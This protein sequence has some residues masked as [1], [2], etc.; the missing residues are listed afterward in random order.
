MT[1]QTPTVTAYIQAKQWIEIAD[2]GNDDFLK[3]LKDR[4]VNKKPLSAKQI[5]WLIRKYDNA[6]NKQ[7]RTNTTTPAPT[8]LSPADTVELIN[9][10]T[11][12]K[13]TFRF[14][15]DLQGKY[16]VNKALSPAQW[17]AVEK[18]Y[19]RDTQYKAPQS[20]TPN[21]VAPAKY[22]AFANPVPVVLTRKGAMALKRKYNLSF[23]PFTVEI[24]GA[25][26]NVSRRGYRNYVMRVNASG[27]VNVCRVCGK[28]L[29]DHKSVVS[30]IGPV[31]AKNL[32]AIYH[33]Y[34]TDIQKFMADFAAQCAAIGNMEIEFNSWAF[35]DGY[36]Q[37]V[38]AFD[39]AQQTNSAVHT[40]AV[41]LAPVNVA[42]ATPAPVLQ[43]IV[44]PV[45]DPVPVLKYSPSTKTIK[46]K[47]CE[48]NQQ[49]EL[50]IRESEFRHLIIQA[51][52]LMVTKT[53]KLHNIDTGKE[54]LFTRVEDV[55]NTF[56]SQIGD[57][58][59]VLFISPR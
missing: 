16:N 6:V 9:Y 5:T 4:V 8:N 11:N 47:D 30:G 20:V 44:S 27:A 28:S 37:T 48:I 32:G 43:P 35:K 41:A 45:N 22:F 19:K 13:G 34:Q 42:T 36:Q 15:L 53:F 29:V 58:L 57:K 3:S 40:P 59:M 55:H 51:G 26:D 46:V 52:F 50:Y 24:L 33:T 38:M 2:P 7:V 23:G 25:Y 31:C 21:V 10:V 39:A 49:I 14:M 17:A 56:K 1:S 54:V 18:C 12:Y